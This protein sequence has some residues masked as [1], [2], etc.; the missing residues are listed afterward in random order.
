[1]EECMASHVKRIERFDRA[2]FKQRD[3][4]NERMAKMF[5]LLKELTSSTMPEKVLVREEVRNP[6]T[7]NVNAIS[8]CKMECE[9]YQSLPKEPM[10][11]VM[12]KK[13]I[14]K[15]VDLGGKFVI[16]CNV[17]G[18]IYMDALVDQG[19]DV[20]VM[21]LSTYNRLTD[22]K[23][24]ETGI[25]LSL[26]SQ[27][28]IYPLGIAEDVLVKIAGFVYPIDFIILDIKEDRKKSF[29]QG[30]TFLTTARAKIKFD[31]GTITLKYGKMFGK[32]VYGDD[33]KRIWCESSKNQSGKCLDSGNGKIWS[34]YGGG[35]MVFRGGSMVVTWCSDG[36]VRRTLGRFKQ[37]AFSKVVDN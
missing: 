30:T 25:R 28:H 26:A 33:L 3:E 5:G 34:R 1:M 11:K 13:M 19:S 32:K 31:K 9:D 4:I 23:L 2:I 21:P 16:P 20:N 7:K 24:V 27:S 29:I 6:I 35:S 12:L 15:K 18:L 14:T 8:L 17:K 22:E 10:H 36:K 37:M